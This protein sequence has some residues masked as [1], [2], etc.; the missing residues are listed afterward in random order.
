MSMTA[1]YVASLPPVVSPAMIY[2]SRRGSG[3]IM[4]GLSRTRDSSLGR[5]E[6]RVPASQK[7]TAL[8]HLLEYPG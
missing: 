1:R 4:G 6:R 3:P 5:R 7:A 8:A 2:A